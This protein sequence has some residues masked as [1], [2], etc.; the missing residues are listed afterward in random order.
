MANLTTPTRLPLLSDHARFV[1]RHRTVIGVLMVLGLLLGLAWSMTQAVTFSS[2]ASVSLAPV[3]KYLLPTGVG[4]ASPGV[5]IDTDAQLLRSTEVLDSVALALGTTSD[6][7]MEQLSVTASPNSHVLHVTVTADSP[8][9]AAEAAN[10]AVTAL[11]RVRRNTLGALRLDQL[12]LLR[13]WTAGQ[14]ELLAQE[15][16]T[17]AVLLATDDLFAQ[18]LELREGLQE[19]EGAR[20]APAEVVNAA[21]PAGSPDYSNSEVPLTSG[22]MLGLLAACLVG[23]RRDRRR[24]L[25]TISPSMR[26]RPQPISH[27]PLPATTQG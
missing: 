6:M 21:V 25:A 22:A 18:V 5:S 12:R 3:P 16:S 4:L 24:S 9:E 7:A 19:L 14:E 10:A 23:V 13:L 27:L 17:R 8:A 11:V 15:Q 1:G 26:S 20:S 2:T